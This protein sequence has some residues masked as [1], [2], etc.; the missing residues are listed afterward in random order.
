MHYL[1][2]NLHAYIIMQILHE[3]IVDSLLQHPGYMFEFEKKGFCAMVN[4]DEVQLYL[5]A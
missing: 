4:F 2:C 1:T 5:T 3:M